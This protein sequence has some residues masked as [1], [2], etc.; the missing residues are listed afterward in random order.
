MLVFRYKKHNYVY[1]YSV[2]VRTLKS[3]T[4]QNSVHKNKFSIFNI[5]TD[6]LRHFWSIIITFRTKMYLTAV[7]FNNFIGPESFHLL[8]SECF[9]LF[10]FVSLRLACS[11]I[12]HMKFIVGDG[13]ASFVKQSQFYMH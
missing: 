9:K 8:S 7:F 11:L 13:D 6:S 4:T 5:R 10:M 12:C 2:I 3:L 1:I